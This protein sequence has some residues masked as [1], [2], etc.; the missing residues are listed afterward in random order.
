A[1]GT[2]FPISCM[3]GKPLINA[4]LMQPHLINL[5]AMRAALNTPDKNAAYQN[6]LRRGSWGIGLA[7]VLSST[8]NFFLVL[9]LLHGKEP[10]SEAFVKGIGVLNWASVI[11]VGVPLCAMML[12]VFVWLIR[13]I[14][15]I[16][17]LGRADLLKP[18]RRIR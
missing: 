16:T 17:G 11:V 4:L 3:M 18:G 7:T 10:G 13:K 15:S 6:V 2:A 9:Y 8:G 14:Q 1:L 12:L 5:G